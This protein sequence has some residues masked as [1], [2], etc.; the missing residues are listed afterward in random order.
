[1]AIQRKQTYKSSPEKKNESNKVAM[2]RRTNP[3]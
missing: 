2:G 1:M 3:G